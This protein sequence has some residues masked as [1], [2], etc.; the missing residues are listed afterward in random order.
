MVLFL[1]LAKL[2]G[3]IIVLPSP[4]N[5]SRLYPNLWKQQA[6]AKLFRPPTVLA[7]YWFPAVN[8]LTDN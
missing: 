8:Q 1:V 3:A 7:V 6:D 2:I 5:D 4:L